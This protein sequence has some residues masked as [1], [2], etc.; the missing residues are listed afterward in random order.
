MPLAL[1]HQITM[2]SVLIGVK[3]CYLHLLLGVKRMERDEED[4]V[5][6]K[7]KTVLHQLYKLFESHPHEK[8]WTKE[9]SPLSEVS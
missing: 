5:R 6:E 7:A 9:A 4:L 1:L 2:S 3:R 8:Q